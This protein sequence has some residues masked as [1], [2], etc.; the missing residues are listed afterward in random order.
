[1]IKGTCV[2]TL[3]I[4]RVLTLLGSFIGLMTGE[5]I[6]IAILRTCDIFLGEFTLRIDNCRF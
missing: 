6:M 5:Q 1:M 4:C 2:T 3:M